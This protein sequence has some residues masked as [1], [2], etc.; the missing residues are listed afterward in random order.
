MERSSYQLLSEAGYIQTV[1]GQQGT[2]QEIRFVWGFFPH[3][4]FKTS[5]EISLE[6]SLGLYWGNNLQSIAS[7]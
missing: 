1:L 5:L 7:L 2:G 4:A 3:S 6:T